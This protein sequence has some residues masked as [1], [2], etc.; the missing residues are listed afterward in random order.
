MTQIDCK[1]AA[2]YFLLADVLKGFKLGL[3]YMFAP[4]ATVNYPHEKGPLSPRFRGEHAL[5]RYPNGEERCIACKL[6]E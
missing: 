1:R 2:G 5:R 4:K 6:C 3:K